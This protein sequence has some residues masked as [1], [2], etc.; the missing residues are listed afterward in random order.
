MDECKEFFAFHYPDE[1]GDDILKGIRIHHANPDPEIARYLCQIP[2]KIG[3]GFTNVDSPRTNILRSELDLCCTGKDIP[4]YIVDN[5]F[6]RKAFQS[7]SCEPGDTITT[8]ADATLCY[9]NNPW[10]S[11]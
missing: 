5:L 8:L 6:S 7:P 11:R 1:S 4:L 10:R 9:L 3:Q 2:E